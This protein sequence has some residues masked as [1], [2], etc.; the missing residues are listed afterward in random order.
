MNQQWLKIL[1]GFKKNKYVLVLAILLIP[2]FFINK[3]NDTDWGDDFAQYI[4]QSQ[5][6]Y[7]AS[8]EYKT[9][10]NAFDHAPAKRGIL[11][12]L[13][14]SI[15]QNW[16]D[17]MAYKNLICVNYFL[18]ALIVFLFFIQFFSKHESLLLVLCIF[19]NYH[20]L[21]LKNEIVAEFLFLMILYFIFFIQASKKIYP[22]LL[23]GF[24]FASLISVRFAGVIFLLAYLFHYLF[25]DKKSGSVFYVLKTLLW[26]IV[27]T[28]VFNTIFLRQ[29][30]NIETEFYQLAF[31]NGMTWQMFLEN[32][33]IYV[34]SI[35]SYFEQELPAWINLLLIYPA[36]LLA[37]FGFMRSLIKQNSFSDFSFLAYILVLLFWDNSGTSKRYLIP[38]LPVLFFYLLSGFKYFLQ[39]FSIKKYALVMTIIYLSIIFVSNVNTI[40]LFK[41]SQKN[42]GPL[43]QFLQN[44]FTKIEKL[45]PENAVIAFNKPLVINL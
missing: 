18:C 4:Y 8:D 16:Q 24:L 33:S 11:F 26:S 1:N 3:T 13:Y 10:V 28:A 23:Y 22:P 14:L 43:N 6:L 37:L 40:L 35:A 21:W 5:H 32:L 31:S 20:N 36:L 9:V 30:N 45:T 19:Y 38:I 25:L 17:V 29:Q 12:S 15:N 27:F 7:H 44:D 34:E 42:T 2:V 39:V 41:H